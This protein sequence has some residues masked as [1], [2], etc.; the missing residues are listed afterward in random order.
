LNLEKDIQ[1][2]SERIAELEELIAAKDQAMK[3]L[4]NSISKALTAFEGKGLTVE[5]RNGKVYVSM[6]NKLLFKSGSWAIGKQGKVAIIE[7]GK[8]LSK[9]PDIAVLIEGHTDNV[10]FTSDGPISNNWDLSTKRAT[11]IISILSENNSINLENL[12]AA[13][14]SEYS[15]IDTN[16]T[17]EGKAKNRRIEVILTPKLDEISRLLNSK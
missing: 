1:Q 4:K 10:P 16:E 8:V 17:Q 9:N 13:G 14:R 12:T 5:Q 11:S 3:D 2:R 6:E 7:L 15:P